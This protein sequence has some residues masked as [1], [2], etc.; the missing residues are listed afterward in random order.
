MAE[1]ESQTSPLSSSPAYSASSSLESAWVASSPCPYW[2]QTARTNG[3]RKV[4]GQGRAEG[5]QGHEADVN[6][7]SDLRAQ[8]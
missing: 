2:T 1:V 8:G 5:L 7:K 3:G 6:F 4:E